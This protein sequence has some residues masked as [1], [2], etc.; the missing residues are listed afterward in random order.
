MTNEAEI[1][2]AIRHYRHDYLNDLQLLHGYAQLGKWDKV[3]EKMNMYVQKANNERELDQLNIPKTSLY[4]YRTNW[5]TNNIQLS[6]SV[7]K[8]V[9]IASNSNIDESLK[10]HLEELI[11]EIHFYENPNELII[12]EL[13]MELET[14]EKLN[15]RLILAHNFKDI[16][17]LT[18]KLKNKKFIADI[19]ENRNDHL[20]INW[21]EIERR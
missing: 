17:K 13:D 19:K 10:Y 8:K 9:D 11:N 5:E 21:V 12:A 4:I 14:S 16:V 7:N 3:K 18:E 1:M 15:I 20:I 2:Q 6:F